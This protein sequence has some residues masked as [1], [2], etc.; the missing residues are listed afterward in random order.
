MSQ[1]KHSLWVLYLWA[2]CIAFNFLGISMYAADTDSQ[3]SQSKPWFVSEANLPEGFPAAGPVDEVIVKTYPQHRLARVQSDS[4]PGQ[5]T[6]WDWIGAGL[7]VFWMPPA[8]V[9]CVHKSR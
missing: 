2:L 8:P 7:F 6:L 1:S 4:G 3:A 5:W 9:D